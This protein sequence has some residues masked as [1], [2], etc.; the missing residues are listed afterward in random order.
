VQTVTPLFEG[1]VVQQAPARAGCGR[2]RMREPVR[3]QVEAQWRTLDEQLPED[4]RARQVWSFVEQLDL[5]DLYGGIKAVEGRPGHP[6]ADPRLLMGLWLY[7]TLEQVG[8][9]RQ[10]DRLCREHLGFRWM[11]GGVGVN[12][13]LLADFRVAHGAVLDRLLTQSFAACLRVGLSDLDRVAQDGVRV[14][15][16]AG[17]ASFRRERTLQECHALAQAELVRLRRELEEDPG[18]ASRRQRAARLRAA[19][20]REERVA[21]ALQAVRALAAQQP[22]ATTPDE[23]GPGGGSAKEQ[24]VKEPRASTTDVEARVMKMADGGFRPAFNV[25][26][27]TAVQG[28]LIAAVSVGTVGSDQGQLA[29]MIAQLTQRYGQPPQEMLVDGGFTKLADIE[30]VSAGG[31]TVYAPVTKPRDPTRD[32]HAPRRGDGPHVIAWRERMATEQAKQIY[33][34]RA[35]TAECVNALA[36][37]RGLQR[38]LVRGTEKAR[39]VVLWFALAHNLMRVAGLTAATT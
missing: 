37:N 38:F 3:N 9:A 7:A 15:A 14:R 10:L 24:K 35:A 39:A 26:I 23:D 21:G 25:Q 29:P 20:E 31:S 27:A 36:R 30:S 11:C 4:H 6:P 32:P 18:A 33:K 28:Q 8:S 22:A 1:L 2:A 34:D 16:S 17:A 5:S 13:H 19:R 12:Y